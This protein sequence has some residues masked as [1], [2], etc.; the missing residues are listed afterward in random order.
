MHMACAVDTPSVSIFGPSDPTRYFSGGSGSPGT[1]HVVVRAELWCSPC[2]QIRRPP[3]ECA[4]PG[5]PECLERVSVAAVYD[6]A[7]ALLRERRASDA[8][9]G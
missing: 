2:N 3:T 7:A 4:G 5:M 1:R 9:R 6:A 8:R